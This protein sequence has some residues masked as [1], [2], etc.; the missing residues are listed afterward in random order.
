MLKKLFSIIILSVV[1]FLGCKKDAPA[2]PAAVVP[3]IVAPPAPVKITDNIYPN[4]CT[5]RFTI[6]TNTTDSQSV[7]MYDVNG[8]EKLDLIINGTTAI[9]DNSLPNGMYNIRITNTQGVINKRLVIVR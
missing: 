3:P 1:F 7:R 8:Q 9:V 4:P 6:Q 5:G 2:Y